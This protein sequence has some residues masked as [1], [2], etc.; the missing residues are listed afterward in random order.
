MTG[1]V[2]YRPG[3]NRRPQRLSAIACDRQVTQAD[4]P[5]RP[6]REPVVGRRREVGYARDD[7][8]RDGPAGHLP[9]VPDHPTRDLPARQAVE[10]DLW[11]GLRDGEAPALGELFDRYSRQVYNFAFRRTASWAVAEEVTQATFVC[12]WRRRR[13]LP[14]D[15][16]TARG[17][18][19]GIAEN[20][21]RNAVRATTRAGRLRTRL[22]DE[23]PPAHGLDPA[24][25]VPARID[26]ERQM[27]SLRAALRRL[28]VRE[29]RTIEL[30]VWSGLSV[31]EAAAS[32]GVAEGTVKSRM[33][34]A[35]ARLTQLLDPT[36]QEGQA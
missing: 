30:V 19:F 28:P 15:L 3:T 27:R 25:V 17:W 33:S 10:T 5:R 23:P 9:V 2:V 6:E 11:L 20:E 8:N 31:A 14:Q 4:E 22:Q 36:P 32:M 26:A 1:Y 35:R 18:M 12:L 13:S 24:D 29:Q 16:S 34:R 7:G 21:C